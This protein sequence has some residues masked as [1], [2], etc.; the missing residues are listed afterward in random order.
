MAVGGAAAAA[1]AEVSF[2][3]DF[4]EELDGGGGPGTVALLGEHAAG[5]RRA[6]HFGK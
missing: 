4:E 3:R 6:G 1:A 2:G 5:S